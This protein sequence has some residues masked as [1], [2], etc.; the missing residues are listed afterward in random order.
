MIK[1]CSCISWVCFCLLYVFPLLGGTFSDGVLGLGAAAGYAL[2]GWR[3][4]SAPP[5]GHV[6]VPDSPPRS[7]LVGVVVAG[8][9]M[10]E[11]VWVRLAWLGWVGQLGEGSVGVV[12]LG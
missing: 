3:S 4:A 5:A 7:A 11:L 10:D 2:G 9:C 1:L 12:G 8:L 6:R